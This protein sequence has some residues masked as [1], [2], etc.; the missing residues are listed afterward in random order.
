MKKLVVLGA[1]LSIWS[2]I[3]VANKGHYEAKQ[4]CCEPI[5]L[6]Q[7]DFDHTQGVFTISES[8]SYILGEDIKGQLVVIGTTPAVVND[9]DT[10]GWGYGYSASLYYNAFKPISFDTI[11]KIL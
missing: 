1:L 2:G 9:L 11:E 8:G 3:T 4:R 5:V 10:S 6:R 7:K